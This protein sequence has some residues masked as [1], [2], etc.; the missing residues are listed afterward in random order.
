MIVVARSGT[1]PTVRCIESLK[2]TAEW[3]SFELI[4]VDCLVSAR[5]TWIQTD[6]RVIVIS[7]NPEWPVMRQRELGLQRATGEIV[8]ILNERYRV[9]PGWVHALL[10]AH[11]GNHDVVSG[12]V[13]PSAELDFAGSAMYLA[14]YWH[15]CPPVRS[16]PLDNSGAAMIS[17]GNVA[18]KR[19]ILQISEFGR[20]TWELDF[21]AALFKAGARFFLE[22]GM[23]ADFAT[24]YTLGEYIRERYVV[25]RDIGHRR[26][27]YFT[28]SRRCLAMA[29][30]AVRPMLLAARVSRRVFRTKVF[31]TKFLLALPWIMFFGGVQGIGE[32]VGY[33]LTSFRAKRHAD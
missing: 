21:H 26:G 13:A 4:I 23:Q 15:I 30:Q 24:P 32:F 14:E 7:A 16:G 29:I 11:T 1:R 22:S 17:G 33:F 6:S 12:P 3:G 25:S 19:S 2:A 8:A 18:Y 10:A 27:E 28:R 31:R 20:A 9:V 5:K